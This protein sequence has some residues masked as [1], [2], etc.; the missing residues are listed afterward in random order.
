M[1]GIHGVCRYC[2]ATAKHLVS[3]PE[4]DDLLMLIW[5]EGYLKGFA[6]ETNIHSECPTFTLGY[7]AGEA[8]LRGYPT[9]PVAIKPLLTPRVWMYDSSELTAAQIT[10]ERQQHELSQREADLY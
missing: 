8:D 10:F 3:C 4:K 7:D 6:G 5:Q 9:P 1:R 2:R